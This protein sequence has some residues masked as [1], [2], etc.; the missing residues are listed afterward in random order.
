MNSRV[1]NIALK[2]PKVSIGM[3]VF[4]GAKFIDEALQSFLVQT[5]EDFELIISDN[6]SSDSTESICR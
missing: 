5:F 2:T 6:A 1:T 3:P 4:N